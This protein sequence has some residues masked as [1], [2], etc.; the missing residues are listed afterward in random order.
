MPTAFLSPSVRYATILAKA[1]VVAGACIALGLLGS[2]DDP[3]ETGKTTI[4]PVLSASPKETP[5]P[6]LS[7]TY[8]E[9]IS[10]SIP[11]DQ[12][13]SQQWSMHTSDQVAGASGLFR[14]REFLVAPSEVVVAI[15]DSGVMFEHEDLVFLPGYDFIHDANVAND[16]DGRDHDPGDPGD[17]VNRADIDQNLVSDGCHISASKWHGTAIAGIIGATSHNAAGIAGGAPAVAML[18]V[19]VTGKCG[20]YVADL[21]DGIRWAAGLSV[22]GAA[23][24]PNP[25]DVINLSVGFEGQCS[26]AMQGAIND[27]VNAG[28][29]VVTASTN[30]AADLNTKPY[31]PAVCNNVITVAATDRSGAITA[32]SALGNNVF[33]TAP[34]GTLSDGIVTTQNNGNETLLPDSAYGSHY[35]TSIAAAHVSAAVANLLSYQPDLTRHQIQQ[36]LSQSVNPIT[37]NSRCNSGQCGFGRL[38][39]YA[40][41]RLLSEGFQFDDEPIADIPVQLAATNSDGNNTLA[42]ASV[43]ERTTAVGAADTNQLVF[44]LLMLLA[45]GVKKRY[46]AR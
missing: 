18:P 34:G 32:Y 3:L 38:D 10:T 37:E 13:A 20:G 21:I 2:P 4:T 43:G 17:W 29:I 24:N 1:C 42:I 30:S 36:L 44:L 8:P 22:D 11:D 26:N 41:L 46:Y 15:V 7:R 19:R 39:A 16:S 5:L 9:F 45:Y 31:S 28:A 33:M 40:A 27:A 23:D 25:A 6:Y 14:A 35:G 12:Y